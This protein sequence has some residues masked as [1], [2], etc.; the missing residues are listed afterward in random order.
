MVMRKILLSL[1][2]V[3]FLSACEDKTAKNG[4]VV[5]I[6]FEGFLNGVQF[7]G[8]TGEYDLVLGS[9]QFIPGFEDQLIGAKKGE[10]RDV[11]LRFPDQYVPGLAGKEV[12]FR[13]TIKDIK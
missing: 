4:D 3:L 5:A 2:A 10:V 13:V 8:G 9:G 6:H 7:E 11:R 12:L 1:F